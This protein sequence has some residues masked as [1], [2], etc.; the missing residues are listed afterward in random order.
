MSTRSLQIV[1]CIGIGALVAMDAGLLLGVAT[2]GAMV[3]LTQPNVV[4][5]D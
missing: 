3:V 4:G 1:V 2:G 5:L